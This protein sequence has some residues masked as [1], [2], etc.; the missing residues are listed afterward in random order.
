MRPTS[1]N[2][3]SVTPTASDDTRGMLPGLAGV[4]IFGL[5]P[6]STLLPVIATVALGRHMLV[7]R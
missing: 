3:A 1:I 2:P 6:P 4:A 5:T 7:R